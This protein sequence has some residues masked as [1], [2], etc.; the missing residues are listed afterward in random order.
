MKG[1]RRT[2][3]AVATTA[4]LLASVAVQAVPAQAD[5]KSITI[6]VE[7]G[8]ESLQ[9]DIA[10]AFTKKTGIAVKFDVVPYQGVYDKLSADLTAGTGAYDVATI[11][12]IWVPAFAKGLVSL[13]D[14]YTPA[15]KADLAKSLVAG[16]Q[17]QG[18]VVGMPQWANSEILFYRK[19]LF[20][21][22]KEKANFK[23]RFGYALT[24]PKTWKQYTDVARFF[25]RTKNGLTSL[26]G[27]DVKGGV[28]TEW[29]AFV[30]QAGGKG[31]VLDA[32][33]KVV[34]NNLAHQKA[35]QFV[36]DLRCKYN[37][38]PA[39]AN[40]IDWGAAQNLFY[41][42]KSAMMLFWG[43]AYR[44]T[45][46]DSKVQGKVGVAPMI[47]GS[48]GVGAIPGPWYNVIP[49]TSKNQDLAK[50]FIQFAYDNNVLGINAPLG[51]AARNS[52]F[53]SFQDKPG[54]EA[55]KPLLATLNGPATYG[56]PANPKW[57]Q[58]TDQ[59]LVPVVQK[60]LACNAPVKTILNQA[61]TQ[62]EAIL[63]G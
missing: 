55:F 24:P 49:K 52:A 19:D 39:A 16:G 32:N 5:G 29:L 59:V 30:N 9:K 18:S 33:N 54:Y 35:L 1:K 43:H 3:F 25:T 63:A 62:V 31:Q 45:P 34:I 36:Q 26:Y 11:D 53:K 12:V 22:A 60:A 4:M 8:G 47:A 20:N 46:D 50:Q 58:I 40:T 17:Y 57:Q 23:K 7:G 10:A 14:M 61:K 15:V 44:L 41:Q 51:L 42:G 13:A 56:R 38:G 27:T 37:V 28:E 2:A 48:A 21:N 6:L